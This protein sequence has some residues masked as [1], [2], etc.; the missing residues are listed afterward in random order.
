MGEGK[1]TE[2]ARN[3]EEVGW[4]WRGSE[5]GGTVGSV[6]IEDEKKD[7]TDHYLR[8]GDRLPRSEKGR[9]KEGKREEIEKGKREEE[10][11]S[12]WEKKK[13]EAGRDQSK[14]L[15]MTTFKLVQLAWKASQP[16]PIHSSVRPWGRKRKTTAGRGR[17]KGGGAAR[18]E[19]WWNPPPSSFRKIWTDRTK[20]AYNSDHRSLF[21]SEK[22]ERG[23]EGEGKT[24]KTREGGEREKGRF[25]SS[26]TSSSSVKE[27]QNFKTRNR[28]IWTGRSCEAKFVIFWA[29]FKNRSCKTEAA[30]RSQKV[31]ARC[32]VV[33]LAS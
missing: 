2:L 26:K 16:L 4:I 17:R 7:P 8:E 10:G 23:K 9:K 22:S 28:K 5:G 18:A 32:E 15:A 13:V 33:N 6:S 21:K 24:W 11:A 25:G 29:R 30:P 20:E 31:G 1:A 19:K 12:S 14:N 3:E 27:A